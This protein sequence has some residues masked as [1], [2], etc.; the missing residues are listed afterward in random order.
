M[1]TEREKNACILL[2]IFPL[3]AMIPETIY[4]NKFR[5]VVKQ[6]DVST[7]FFHTENDLSSKITTNNNLEISF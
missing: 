2:I 1:I 3:G 4:A 7:K 5:K 6:G